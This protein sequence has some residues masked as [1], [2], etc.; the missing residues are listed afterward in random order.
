MNPYGRHG[1]LDLDPFIGHEL[2]GAVTIGQHSFFSMRFYG[3]K[4]E[5]ISG[6]LS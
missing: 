2:P 5:N 1:S 3:I 6:H 4:D